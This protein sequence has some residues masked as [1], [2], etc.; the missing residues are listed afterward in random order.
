[1]RLCRRPESILYYYCGSASKTNS[2]FL[3]KNFCLC[4]FICVI[5][6][7]LGPMHVLIAGGLRY[8]W[9]VFVGKLQEPEVLEQILLDCFAVQNIFL[10]EMFQ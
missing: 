9:G 7:G 3:D 2:I 6:I 5:G 10:T 4:V 1:M 8:V